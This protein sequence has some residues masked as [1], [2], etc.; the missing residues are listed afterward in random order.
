MFRTLTKS[1]YSQEFCYKTLIKW[2]CTINYLIEIF[3]K[4]LSIISILKHRIYTKNFTLT[5]RLNSVSK[6]S[7]KTVILIKETFVEEFY[8]LLSVI[9][10]KPIHKSKERLSLWKTTRILFLML[11]YIVLSIS[12]ISYWETK[13]IKHL[14]LF[15]IILNFFVC[16]IQPNIIEHR[17]ILINLK[18]S[19]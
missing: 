16:F 13:R 9:I 19:F 7:I 14:K 15:W 18:T 3:C 11:K 1:R 12:Y 4:Y 17:I 10:P 2:V 8:K 5:S 6:K